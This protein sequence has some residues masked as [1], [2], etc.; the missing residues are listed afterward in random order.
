MVAS[1]PR[2]EKVRL[3]NLTYRDFPGGPVAQIV[4]YQCREPCLTPVLGIKGFPGGVVVK[5]PPANARDLGLIPESGR[6]PKG[7]NDNPFQYSCLKKPYGRRSQAGFSLCGRIESD[8]TE[9]AHMHA[10]N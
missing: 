9:H 7:G 5:S 4:H 2:Q 8:M 1:I 10:G 3:K 6:S